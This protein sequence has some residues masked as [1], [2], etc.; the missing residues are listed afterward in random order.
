MHGFRRLDV[1]VARDALADYFKS[2]CDVVKMWDG[3]REQPGEMR[4]SWGWKGKK[5]EVY[6][7]VEWRRIRD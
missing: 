5:E 3:R 2:A 4:S 6:I 1:E 7:V